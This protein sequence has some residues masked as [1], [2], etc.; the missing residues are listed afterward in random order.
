MT[1]YYNV[2]TRQHIIIAS[3]QKRNYIMYRTIKLVKYGL[4]ICVVL[5][6]YKLLLLVK[7]RDNA[8]KQNSLLGHPV[9]NDLFKAAVTSAKNQKLTQSKENVQKQENIEIVAKEEK[10]EAKLKVVY[11]PLDGCMKHTYLSEYKALCFRDYT[12]RR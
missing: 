2:G 8:S 6:G 4:L 12:Y 10:T 3:W 1:T 5:V 7:E 11:A 9:P